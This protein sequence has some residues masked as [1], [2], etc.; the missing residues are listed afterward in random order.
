MGEFTEVRARLWDRDGPGAHAY[1]GDLARLARA[2]WDDVAVSAVA[3][4][5]RVPAPDLDVLE[6]LL[7]ICYQASLL[8]EEARPV[9]FRLALGEPELFAAAQGPPAGLHR[10]MFTKFRPLDEHELRRL[11]P[12]AGFHRSLI[13]AR[14]DEDDVIQ[15][16][17]LVH[18]G[19]RWL[20]SVR[21][22]RHTEQF[23][24]PVPMVVVTG[25]GRVLV[26]RGT[27]TLAALAEGSLTG[28]AMDVF[29]A[30]WLS[31]AFAEAQQA[32]W[33]AH[34]TARERS[35][36]P[37]GALDPRVGTVLAQH[38]VRRIVS[39]IR[40]SR[41][42]GTLILL[43]DRC[44]REVLAGSEYL[45]LKY[46]FSDEEPRRRIMS[47]IVQIMNE[48]ARLHA[49]AGPVGW[50]EYEASPAPQ[51]AVLDEAL[52]EVAHLIAA[53]ADVDGAVVMTTQLEL[54][55]FGGEISGA[56]PEVLTVN[57][58][59]DVEGAT[60]A[61][62]LTERVGTRHRSSYRLS[63]HLRDAVLIVV[64]HDGGVR[65]VR[66]HEHNVMCWDQIATG[67]WEV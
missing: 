7:S 39:T 58:A 55:G 32:Q 56:L 8:R 15:I 10:L 38:V 45:S 2:S 13:A 33:I 40:E 46:K 49:V 3:G 52:F 54:L 18:S 23:I 43:P 29:S 20:Q 19:A 57:R 11:A 63:R 31:A 66:W 27:T 50:A 4:A 48:L 37:W 25:P 17:G 60:Y 26:S 62:E 44:A 30:P 22:G 41:Q 9:T 1:P 53:L 5:S 61:P 6:R 12:A 47:L 34:V 14:L 67:P 21:G 28:A 16:W 24:P 36:A 59:L 42:G 35:A 51:L 65:F 64:S